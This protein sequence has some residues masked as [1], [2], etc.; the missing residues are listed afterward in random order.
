MFWA[1]QGA[2]YVD[3]LNDSGSIIAS[4][5][6]WRVGGGDGTAPALD[7]AGRASLLAGRPVLVD[8]SGESDLTLALAPLADRGRRNAWSVRA[9]YVLPATGTITRQIRLLTWAQAI[10]GAAVLAM[11]LAFTRFVLQPYRALRA[12]AAGLE[13]EGAQ[14]RGADDPAFLVA[15]FRGV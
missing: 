6:I 15:S 12:T 3:L 10:G 14:A 13:P 1:A 9:A 11:V 4:S 7:E 5:Q 2:S 8:R